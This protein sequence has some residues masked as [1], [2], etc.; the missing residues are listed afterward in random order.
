MYVCK[1]TFK[2]GQ[3]DLGVDPVELTWGPLE[4]PTP[5]FDGLLLAT[6][7][8]PISAFSPCK[9]GFFFLH[10]MLS[11]REITPQVD[12]IKNPFHTRSALLDLLLCGVGL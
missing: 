11:G 9:Q 7:E 10:F 2:S 6:V 12:Q 3:P 8:F 5:H 4:V 1:Y